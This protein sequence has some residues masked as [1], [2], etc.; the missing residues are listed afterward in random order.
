M[1]VAGP[2]E[3]STDAKVAPEGKPNMTRSGD[4]FCS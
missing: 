2:F 1:S 3:T 4:D